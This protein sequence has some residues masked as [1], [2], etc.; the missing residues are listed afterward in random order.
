MLL[1]LMV[2]SKGM[3]AV[4]RGALAVLAAIMPSS[5]CRSRMALVLGI[6]QFMD[7]GRTATNVLGN[8]IATSVIAKWRVRSLPSKAMISRRDVLS[9]GGLVGLVGATGH[10]H[11]GS[12]RPGKSFSLWRRA[13]HPAGTIPPD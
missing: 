3:A 7:M 1:I 2:S 13:S 4:P 12:A 6:D 8:S 10:A 9:A 11:A 5:A